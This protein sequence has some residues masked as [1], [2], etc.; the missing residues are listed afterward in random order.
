M[1]IQQNR[2]YVAGP[3]SPGITC[4][5]NHSVYTDLISLARFETYAEALESSRQSYIAADGAPE[6][7]LSDLQNR[8]ESNQ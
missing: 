8:F 7:T 3:A 1:D 2:L 6:H 4:E 5:D